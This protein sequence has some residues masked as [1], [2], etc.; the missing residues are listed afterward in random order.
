MSLVCTL[1]V[2]VLRRSWVKS[3]DLI[4]NSLKIGK[5]A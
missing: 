2:G 4:E 3:K 5:I 1:A